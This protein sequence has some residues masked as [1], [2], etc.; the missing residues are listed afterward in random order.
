M[1]TEYA[2]LTQDVADRVELTHT[3]TERQQQM[4]KVYED[5]GDVRYEGC[6]Y[7]AFA[8]WWRERVNTIETRG[9]RLF[10]EPLQAHSVRTLQHVDDAAAVLSS[11]D[12]LLLAVPKHMQR[13][14]IDKAIDRILR[15]NVEFQKGRASRNPKLS[16]A[17]YSLSTPVLAQSMKKA[18]DIYDLRAAATAEGK[19]ITNDT[20]AKAAKLVYHAKVNNNEAEL[21]PAERRRV[22]S[23]TVSRHYKDA[24]TMIHNA[25]IGCFPK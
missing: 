19:K 15:K 8:R 11:E 1:N 12:M 16:L 9:V 21:T 5:F 20:V 23:A 2:K 7:V 24:K 10:A 4:L 18:F 25:A 17:R 6:R 14:H 13:Q 3:S 22:V